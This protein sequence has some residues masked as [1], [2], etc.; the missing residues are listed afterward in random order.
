MPLTVCVCSK[1]RLLRFQNKHGE[2]QPGRV[3][4][5]TTRLQHEKEDKSMQSE[6]QPITSGAVNKQQSQ[7]STVML[8]NRA[9]NG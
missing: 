2:R 3:V 4:H 8:Q 7:S 9:G 1:C 5:D 6:A